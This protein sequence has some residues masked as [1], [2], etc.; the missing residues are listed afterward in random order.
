MQ[1]TV[2]QQA[3]I[4]EDDDDFENQINENFLKE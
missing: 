1:V 3:D 2:F 4:I